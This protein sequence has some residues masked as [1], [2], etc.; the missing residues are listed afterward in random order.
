M[1]LQMG[2]FL[3][4][5]VLLCLFGF[6]RGGSPYDLAVCHGISVKEV[7]RSVRLIIQAV[8]SSTSQQLRIKFPSSQHDEQHKLA[9]G[10]E[11]KSGANFPS[12][13]A[14]ID[15]L[16][17]WTERPSKAQCVLSKCGPK[18][19]FCSRKHKFGLNM[20]GTVDSE[21]RFLDVQIAHP[22]AT[23]DYLAFATSDLKAKLEEPGFLAP[24]LVVFGDNAYSNTHYMVTPYKG[25]V[26][27]DQDS[28][29]FFHSQL[30]IQVECAFG[31]LV[32]RWGILRRPLSQTYGIHRTCNLVLALCRLHNF[33]TNRRLPV[34]TPMAL[35]DLHIASASTG[36]NASEHN[37]T[38]TTSSIADGENN[39]NGLLHGSQHHHDSNRNIRR[40]D[41][42]RAFRLFQ[43]TTD[44]PHVL[45]QQLLTESVVNQGLKRPRPRS[46]K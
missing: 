6:L 20:M 8:N 38:T 46:W 5:F 35:D 12:C 14:A 16:L 33:C 22:A 34:Y 3:D 42:R 10:F 40:Q 45:P 11:E 30:R 15:G 31:K 39:I 2:W 26:T 28:F 23:S 18:K 27:D 29:N 32:H 25:K 13:V 21:G 19:F 1:V 7:Y 36:I 24:G 9:S 44:A 4:Q 37:N 17:I 41:A 43:T